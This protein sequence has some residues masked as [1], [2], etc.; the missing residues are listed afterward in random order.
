MRSA[1]LIRILV[2]IL[3]IVPVVLIGSCNKSAEDTNRPVIIQAFEFT[4]DGESTTPPGTL[5]IEPGSV[6][7]IK[8][9]YVD[10]DAGDDPDPNWY[11]FTWA[12]ERIGVGTSV[13]NPNEYF[14][15]DEEN[16]CIWTAPDVT[17]FYRFIVEIRDKYATPSQESVV[18]EVNANKQPVITELTVSNARPFVNQIVTITVTADDPDDDFPLEYTWQ[19]TGGYFASET[20]GEAKWLSPASGDF[21]ITVIV[22]DQEGGSVSRDVPIVV[23]ANHDPIVQGWDLDPGDSVGM[24]Q[25]VTIT[26]TAAD[27]DGDTLEYNW[28]ADKG[29]FNSVNEN[30]AVWRSPGDAGACKVTCVVE[31]NK[32]G[33]DTAEILINVV[34]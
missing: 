18:V 2:G 29:T 12:V 28:S 27:E 25:L 16:P 7:T 10:P 30:V 32:G 34:E 19:A 17:G 26:L 22:E 8:V 15:V 4:V 3:L 33:S 31:D 20:D 13:F 23:Q 6:L 9:Q 11:T 5:Q 1:A 24:N 14:I 21:T